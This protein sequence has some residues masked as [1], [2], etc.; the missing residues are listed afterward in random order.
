MNDTDEILQFYKDLILS[1]DDELIINVGEFEFKLFDVEISGAYR[2]TFKFD[3]YSPN[4][5]ISFSVKCLKYHIEYELE[6]QLRFL[7]PDLKYF[8]IEIHDSNEPI[9]YYYYFSENLTKNILKSIENKTVVHYQYRALEDDTIKSHQIQSGDFIELT[10]EQNPIKVKIGPNSDDDLSVEIFLK[11]NEARMKV[12]NYKTGKIK[13]LDVTNII[14]SLFN[15][16]IF[17]YDLEFTEN[18]FDEIYDYFK[19]PYFGNQILFEESCCYIN[20][21]TTLM[22]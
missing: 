21:Y 6:K 17:M 2:P 16:F 8:D 14:V 11:V 3:S 18:N 19:P 4:E 5:D 12:K 20:I 7:S 15:D 10:I 9:Q 13:M 22:E 1:G